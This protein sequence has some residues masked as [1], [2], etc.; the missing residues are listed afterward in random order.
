MP[1]I[2]VQAGRPAAGSLPATASDGLPSTPAGISPA[3]ITRYATRGGP[4]ARCRRGPGLDM[5][6]LGKDVVVLTGRGDDH[7]GSKPA[8]KELTK[9]QTYTLVRDTDGVWRIAA[10]HNTERQSVMER[11]PFLYSPATAPKAER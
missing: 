9:V 10:F 8:L 5:R 2:R 4:A 1:G 11:F 7:K 6:F 3:G